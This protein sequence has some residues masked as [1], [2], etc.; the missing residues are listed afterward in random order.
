MAG[1]TH[2]NIGKLKFALVLG[3]FASGVEAGI[4]RGPGGTVAQDC[5]H[6]TVYL[7]EDN[8]DNIINSRMLVGGDI[9]DGYSH[10]SHH[11]A[12]YVTPPSLCWNNTGH[13]IPP[14][15][16]INCTYEFG[17]GDPLELI[18]AVGFPLDGALYELSWMI[19]D[20]TRSWEFT[21]SSLDST[22]LNVAMPSDM[23]TGSYEVHL[24]FRQIAPQGMIF[25]GFDEFDP[26]H[27]E[28]FETSTGIQ[29]YCG[30]TGR[31]SRQ[32]EA[33]A[34]TTLE[35]RS[36]PVPESASIALMLIGGLGLIRTRIKR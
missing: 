9:L 18:G 25:F 35:I 17:L 29:T 20:D 24:T 30:Q 2:L 1:N 3:F 12:V 14:E 7:M 26:N 27:C 22:F 28:E 32:V 19:M 21:S 34:H 4:I 5:F 31:A 16:I 23:A 10:D 33:M 6:Q 11:P 36:I 15:D 13:D 8:A